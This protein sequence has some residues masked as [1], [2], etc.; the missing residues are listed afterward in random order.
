MLLGDED[1][2]SPV[3]GTPVHSYFSAMSLGDAIEEFDQV[4]R[5]G[6][7]DRMRDLLERMG[8]DGRA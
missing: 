6:E 5:L 4:Y 8:E 7:G 2:A 1:A 3:S